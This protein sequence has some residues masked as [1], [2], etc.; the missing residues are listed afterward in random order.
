MS[1]SRIASVVFVFFVFFVWVG[2]YLKYCDPGPCSVSWPLVVLG[3]L[4]TIV[5]VLFWFM[6]GKDGKKGKE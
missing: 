4:F 5:A 6:P 1:G 2:S 3:V